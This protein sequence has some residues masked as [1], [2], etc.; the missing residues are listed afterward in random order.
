MREL[1]CNLLDFHRREQKPQWWKMFDRQE[2][3]DEELAD[4][5]ECLGGLT[6]S[7]AIPVYTEK[8]SQVYT[9]EF[10][11]QETKL[12]VGDSCQISATLERAGEIVGLDLKQRR[13]AIKRG[14]VSGPL[15]TRFSA[16][17]EPPLDESFEM[18]CLGLLRLKFPPPIPTGRCARFCYVNCRASR[19]S[20]LDSRSRQKARQRF[21]PRSMRLPIS[22]TLICSSRDHPDRARP[23]PHR[24]RSST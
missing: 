20:K 17:P 11:E 4:D 13:V 16:I 3:T 21:R 10:P 22:A 9:Y 12:D 18:L 24:T 19:E 8:R 23:I 7:R 2:R 15:P 5:A 14:I 1:I 6:L